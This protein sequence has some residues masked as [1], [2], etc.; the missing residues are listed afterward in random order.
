VASPGA[1]TALAAN[2][3]VVAVGSTDQIGRLEDVF[4]APE[5]VVA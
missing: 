3:V 1:D 5:G 2:D 4:A